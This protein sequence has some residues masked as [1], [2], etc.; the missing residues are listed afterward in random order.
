[1]KNSIKTFFVIISCFA[2]GWFAHF[3][4]FD[5]QIL[6]GKMDP[7]VTAR[8]NGWYVEYNPKEVDDDEI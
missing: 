6:H 7:V 2:C 4:Y 8:N 5:Y 1:M 3:L